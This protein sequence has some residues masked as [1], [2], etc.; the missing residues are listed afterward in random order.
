MSGHLNV[1]KVRDGVYALG[2]PG[3][4]A[5][6][7]CQWSVERGRYL[8]CRGKRPNIDPEAKSF[9]AS[10]TLRAKLRELAN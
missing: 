10:R 1:Y 2:R 6:A 4:K 7:S 8:G 3:R 9:K 5:V